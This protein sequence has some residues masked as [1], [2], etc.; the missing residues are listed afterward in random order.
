[1]RH[2]SRT[3]TVRPPAVRSPNER[4]VP[5]SDVRDTINALFGSIGLVLFAVR[6]F[7][8]AESAHLGDTLW[9]VQVW[10]LAAAVW[11]LLSLRH[12]GLALRPDWGDV[13]VWLLAGGHVLSALIV[14]ATEGQKRAAV[15]MA[16]EWTGV[17]VAVTMLRQWLRTGKAWRRLYHL[18]AVAGVVLSGLGMWQFAVWYPQYGNLLRELMELEQVAAEEGLDTGELSR[19]RDLRS[20]LGVIGA[21]ADPVAR[22]VLRQRVLASTEPLGRFALANTFGGL[23]AVGI[24]LLAGMTVQLRSA[25]RSGIRVAAVAL[26]WILSGYCLVLTKSRTA[27]LGLLAG[28]AAWGMGLRGTGAISRQAWRVTGAGLLLVVLLFGAAWWSGAVDRLVIAESPKSVRYRLEYWTGTWGVI[29]DAP[30]FGV[31]GAGNFRQHYLRHKLAGSSEEILDPHNFVLDVWANGGIAG[32]AGLAALSW[33]FVRRI[34]KSRTLS[35]ESQETTASWNQAG[36]VGRFFSGAGMVGGLALGAVIIQ[37]WA[38]EAVADTQALWLLGGWILASWII[39]AVH[40]QAGAVTAATVALLVHLL[41][42]GGIAMPVICVL[43]LLFILGPSRSTGVGDAASHGDVRSSS[44]GVPYA[45]RML[46][47]VLLTIGGVLVPAVPV[48]LARTY[49]A[50]GESELRQR[51]DARSARR[52]FLDAAQVDP[53][54]PQPWHNLAQLSYAQSLPESD[55]SA[56]LFAEAMS[57]LQAAIERDPVAPKLQWLAAE[58]SLD[59]HGRTGDESLLAGAVAHAELAAMGYPHHSGIRATLAEAYAAAGRGRDAALEAQQ[60]LELDQLNR[61]LA[62]YD[63]LLDDATI[64]RLREIAQPDRGQDG[65]P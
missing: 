7:V 57:Q 3:P 34:R 18:I 43:L 32:L 42:A 12:T 19:L 48:S 11:W 59:R 36:D 62:H 55:D 40:P 44:R 49:V 65:S 37:Q 30:V 54:D 8:P 47:A 1:M 41:G 29:R 17:A 56:E 24:L 38:L 27:W 33:W 31:G 5:P 45:V 52:Y 6:L 20:E 50:A 4:R 58:W 16:W 35:D 64:S 10:L 61:D 53:L 25:Q 22:A 14:V 63:R 23:L 39:P 26:G 46:A 28:V 60:A 15:N 2:K 51:G 13:A 9:V 21:E